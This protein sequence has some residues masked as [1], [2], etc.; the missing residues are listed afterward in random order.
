M[1]YSGTI[2]V[3]NITC[4]KLRTNMDILLRDYLV[5]I[6][7]KTKTNQVLLLNLVAIVTN[8]KN[9]VVACG[10]E[11][12][13][14]TTR[15]STCITGADVAVWMTNFPMPNKMGMQQNAYGLQQYVFGVLQPNSTPESVPETP[16]SH[17][18][19]NELKTSQLRC[20]SH[21]KKIEAEPRDKKHVIPW[22]FDVEFTLTRSWLGT[23][24]DPKIANYQ[25]KAVFWA[26]V[27]AKFLEWTGNPNDY[28][29]AY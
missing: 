5:F 21:K 1:M 3:S 24:E 18:H 17:Q 4:S 25:E 29:T 14:S 28:C 11:Y 20:R 22:K 13:S 19:T 23:S 10:H 7:F 9:G 2:C 15:S 27:R 26:C 6:H 8:E 16:P 12:P